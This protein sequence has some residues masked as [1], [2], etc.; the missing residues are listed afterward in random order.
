MLCVSYG[1]ICMSTVNTA[2]GAMMGHEKVTETAGIGHCAVVKG[3]VSEPLSGPSYFASTEVLD[4]TSPV[5]DMLIKPK[6]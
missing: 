1:S 2:T 3:L 5:A 4:G 6:A